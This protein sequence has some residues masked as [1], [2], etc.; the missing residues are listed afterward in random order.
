MSDRAVFEEAANALSAALRSLAAGEGMECRR[1][2]ACNRAAVCEESVKRSTKRARRM[3]LR[4][5]WSDV[6]RP[7]PSGRAQLACGGAWGKEARGLDRSCAAGMGGEVRGLDWLSGSCD[8]LI[9]Q[10]GYVINSNT[11][12]I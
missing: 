1:R 5:R 10:S 2:S 6:I 9:G 3:G 8:R 12:Y 4:C 7:G 11:I